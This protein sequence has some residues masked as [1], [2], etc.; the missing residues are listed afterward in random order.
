M[1]I[2]GGQQKSRVNLV[3]PAKGWNWDLC[4]TWHNWLVELKGGK[5]WTWAMRSVTAMMCMSWKIW[6]S[7]NLRRFLWFTENLRELIWVWSAQGEACCS[8]CL[9]IPTWKGSIFSLKY[10]TIVKKRQNYATISFK[11]WNTW[12]HHVKSREWGCTFPWTELLFHVE[13]LRLAP[14]RGRQTSGRVG[15]GR[16]GLVVGG[17]GVSAQWPA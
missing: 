15:S 5:W 14:N 11:N 7:Y 10:S 12:C 17:R 13:E 16:V 8:H 6:G 3:P 4:H 1:R 2:K 9:Y